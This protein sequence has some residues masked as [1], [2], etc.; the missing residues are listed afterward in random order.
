MTIDNAAQASGSG[1]PAGATGSTRRACAIYVHIPFCRRKCPYCDFY[2]VPLGGDGTERVE[3]FLA[4]LHAEIVRHPCDAVAATVYFGGG[5]PSILAP[6]AL[7]AV[8]EAIGERWPLAGGAEVSLEA[9]PGTVESEGLAQLRTAGFTRV[10]LGVQSLQDREL[11]A[12][13]RIHDRAGAVAAFRAARAAGFDN[14]GVDLIYGIPGQELESWD[15]TLQEVIALGP[16][17]VSTYELTV[18]EGTELQAAVA[19]GDVALPSEGAVLAMYDWARRLL[20]EAGYCHYEISN[21]ARPGRECRHNVSYWENREYI[22]LGPSACSFVDGRRTRNCAD[23]QQYVALIQGQGCAH[24]EVEELAVDRAAGEALMLGL[25]LRRG[26]SLRHLEQVYG[27]GAVTARGE[28]LER[29]ERLGLLE[30]TGDCVRV[31]DAGLP[32]HNEVAAALL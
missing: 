8:L 17:H 29:L 32:L 15:T 20:V 24:T 4:A 25:R 13:G 1:R 10:S 27:S 23:V 11:R 3:G 31:S 21:F 28:E 16:E 19:R 14:V 5:T 7:C 18:E 26:V 22:G 6:E 2:S 30:R 12:L 9:N